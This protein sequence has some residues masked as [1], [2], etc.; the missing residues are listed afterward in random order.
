VTASAPARPRILCYAPYNRW[1][2]HG[3]WEMTVLHAARLRG[4]DVHYVL[5][6]GLYAECDQF[7]A[8][9]E[10]R[11]RNACLQCQAAQTQLVGKLGMDFTWLGRYL[12]LEEPRIAR[13]WVAGLSRDELLSA[14]YGD[15]DV[16]AWVRGSLHS[17]FRTSSLDPADPKVEDAV[18]GYLYS[19][20]VACFALDRLLEDQQPDVLFLFNG[21][22]SS[23]RVARELAG[24]RGIRT[25]CHE[26]GPRRE[27]LALAVDTDSVSLEPVRRYWE[28]WGDV[29]LTE[30]ELEAIVAH[31]HEREHGRGLGW[32]A[33]TTAPQPLAEVRAA[34]G[35]SPERPTWVLYTSSDDEVVSEA[36]Y[37]GAF[38]RQIEWVE[39]SVAFARAHPEIDLVIRVHPNTGSRRSTGANRR[40]LGELARLRAGLPANVRM[41]DA[42]DDVSSYTLMEIATVGLVYHSTAGLELACKGKAT[43]VGAGNAVAGLPFVE[44]VEHADTYDALLEAMLE[45]PA[46]ATSTEVARLAHRFAYGLFFRRC[47]EFPLVGM[48]S[49]SVGEPRWRRISDLKPGSDPGLDRCVRVLVDGEAVCPPPDAAARARSDAAELAW[50][51]A[52]PRPFTGLAFAEE[53]I[54]DASLLRAWAEAFPA[55]AGHTL[56]IQTPPGATDRLV[57]AVGRAGLGDDDGPDL[58]AVDAEPGALGPVDVVLSARACAEVDAPH[59]GSGAVDALRALAAARTA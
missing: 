7:W 21:R 15:W 54:A 28:E 19:G 10:P 26:R 50:F 25:V 38:A 45:I 33:F 27:T 13:A 59:V 35:L 2:L 56:V 3:L 14:R 57:D 5:C 49:A 22:Q 37:R 36:S 17:H 58:V 48:P 30:P 6:D 41:V 31:L 23:T 24:R 16:A 12:T 11:P 55:G 32:K 20:L 51:G 1:A 29:P 8:A 53:L 39:R 46:G 52:P 18:R 43:V 9:T 47:I 34:L 44:T 40:Q 4:A 42:T